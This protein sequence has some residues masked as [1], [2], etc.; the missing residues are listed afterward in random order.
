[1]FERQSRNSQQIAAW[2]YGQLK[3][4]MKSNNNGDVGFAR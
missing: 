2:T 3:E 4:P 1:M